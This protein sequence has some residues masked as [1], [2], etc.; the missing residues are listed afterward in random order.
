M[1]DLD[2]LS[3][4]KVYKKLSKKAVLEN[5]MPD[6]PEDNNSL[7]SKDTKLW[8]LEENSVNYSEPDKTKRSPK[9]NE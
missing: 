8:F 4:K 5:H 9:R 3:K 7:I 1:E 6:K 2:K